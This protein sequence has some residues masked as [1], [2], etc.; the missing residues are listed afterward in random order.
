MLVRVLM[1]LKWPVALGA[2]A[3]LFALGYWVHGT[4]RAGRAEAEEKDSVQVPRRAS[5]AA[6][7]LKAAVAALR[8]VVAAPAVELAWRPPHVVYGRVVPNPRATVEVRAP[9]AGTLQEMPGVN[10]PSPGAQL[11]SGKE[12]GRLVI[13][14][15]PQ[16]RL[17]LLVKLGEARLRQKGSDEI[18]TILKERAKRLETVSGVVS[19][20]ERDA[21]LVRV[22]EARIQLDTSRA[23][24]KQW[25]D[26]LAAI[27]GKNTA[28][29]Q[30]LMAPASGEV[31]ELLGRPGMVV[32]AGAVIARVV[33]FRR[34]LVRVDI[35]VSALAEGPPSTL[36]LAA[37]STP[38]Q[39]L[40]GISNR[41]EASVPA[42]TVPAALV[43]PA[44]QVDSTSQL[45][46]YWYE[47]DTAGPSFFGPSF[48]GAT[49]RPGLFVKGEMQEPGTPPRPA[50]VVPFGALL[51][52]QGRA[53]VYVAIGPD[54]Y[55][56]REVQVLGRHAN[57]WVLA[58]GPVA[59][60]EPVVGSG[61][62]VLLSEEFRGEA[63]ND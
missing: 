62:Q 63:D 16:D 33:D 4:M 24:V 52:H 31:T 7:R 21:A 51:F 40:S 30:V 32:E 50:V 36:P 37:V 29:T 17:D 20:T 26:A 60:G 28:W 41:P 22:A 8:G 6:V 39:A 42:R 61:A 25:E 56:R 10:W 15:T 34:A 54:R 13:R 48:A 57:G 45:A 35:P 9:F 44:P 38:S 5:N 46:G 14:V 18:L 12:L 47:V 11:K 43:G 19:Q 23:A 27:D 3:G 55:E 59:P 49:W 1:I 58:A 53:L 2:L